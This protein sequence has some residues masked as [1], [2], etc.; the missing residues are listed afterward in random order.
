MDSKHPS[1]RD[2]AREAHVSVSA[3]SHAFNR[4]D[5][6]SSDVRQR[7]LRVAQDRG[8]R[9]DPRARG[10]RRDES[11]LIALVINDLS[12]GF[13]AALARAVQHA[14][15]SHEYYLVVLTG[16]TPD[17]E[18]RSLEAVYHERMAGAIVPAY[19]LPPA[20]IGRHAG[21]R[22]IVFITDSSVAFDG[23]SVRVANRTAAHAATAHLAALGRRHIAHIAG[24]LAVP[25]GSLRHLG[26]RQ[27][28]EE[29]GL[30]PPREAA[31]EFTFL[32]G[33]RA[34]EKLLDAAERP[35]AV[36]AAND[37]MA[38][39]ALRV[40]QA[41]G[42]AVP[43]DVAVIGFDNIEEAAWS[44]PPLT[45]MDHAVDQIGTAAARLFLTRLHESSFVE[46]VDI[47]CTLVRRQSA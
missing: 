26:Y 36:F 17:D 43:D 18:R 12:N 30:G 9:P 14:V 2:I 37:A 28:I 24:S 22:P 16:G 20:E 11:R 41:R 5:E 38:I 1:I 46:T 13:N 3:V 35:D 47:A 15:T 33:R 45:T 42:I 32:G 31:G 25:P 6:L 44:A 27:A 10:L 40:L 4:P 21:G 34:M 19:S 23:P 8:Y 7:I 39:G 29:A